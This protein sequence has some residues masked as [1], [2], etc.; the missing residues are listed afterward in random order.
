MYVTGGILNLLSTFSIWTYK[1][2]VR[3][4][5]IDF[6]FPIINKC[7]H[8][9]FSPTVN[10]MIESHLIITCVTRLDRSYRYSG[11][12]YFEEVPRVLIW[13]RG[14]SCSGPGSKTSSQNQTKPLLHHCQEGRW[15]YYYI[16][17]KIPIFNILNSHLLYPLVLGCGEHVSSLGILVA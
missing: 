10:H 16:T 6:K 5:H 17:T 9:L 3:N 2:L 14:Y 11:G 4:T 13:V 8:C 12:G 7:S 15:A 1:Y